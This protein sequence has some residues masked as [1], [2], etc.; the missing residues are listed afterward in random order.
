MNKNLAHPFYLRKYDVGYNGKITHSFEILQVFTNYFLLQS[1]YFYYLC[2]TAEYY[3]QEVAP[4]ADVNRENVRN[5][6]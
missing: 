6:G 3:N 4:T 2:I 1:T 5:S